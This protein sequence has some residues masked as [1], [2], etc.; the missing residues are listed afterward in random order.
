MTDGSHPI[1]VVVVAYGDDP[2][3]RRCFDAL[4]AQRGCRLDVVLIENGAVGEPVN[5]GGESARGDGGAIA[6]VTRVRRERNPGF[7][8]AFGE[9]LERTTAGW[10]ASVNPDCVLEPC[11]LLRAIETGESAPGIGAV[12]FRLFRPGRER[13]DSAGIRVDPRLWRA[14]DRGFG[15]VPT[16]QF[17]R[18]TDVDAACLGAALLR[19]RAIDESRDGAGEVLDHRYFAYQEDVDLGWRLRRAGWRVAYAPAAVGEHERR[20]R[21]GTRRSIPVFLRRCS[22]RNRLTTILKN[23]PLAALII[24]LPV[25]VLFEA[26]LFGYLVVREPAVVPAYLSW[27]WQIPGT[28]RRRGL[29]RKNG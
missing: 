22:L 25:L 15:E 29:Y 4:R 11:A 18:P 27:I 5:L 13:V 7:A 2:R 19:R 20:W 10:I 16:S 21:E 24:R 6:T 26:A 1:S 23:A 12:A 9:A 28:L 3:L 14:R 8:G 17:E